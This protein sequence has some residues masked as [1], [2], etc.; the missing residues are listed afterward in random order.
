L[1]ALL[2][3]PHAFPVFIIGIYALTCVRYALAGDYGRVLY[4]VC[5]AGITFSATFMVGK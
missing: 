5:A 1:K 3:H 2:M 4:W